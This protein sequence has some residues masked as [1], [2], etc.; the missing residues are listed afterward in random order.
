METALPLIFK[1]KIHINSNDFKN[2][3]IR[4]YSFYKSKKY[5]LIQEH[6]DKLNKIANIFDSNR[7]Q[8]KDT[9]IKKKQY[10]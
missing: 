9:L 3:K 5:R 2:I 7:K 4:I 6:N 10:R 1:N 8:S